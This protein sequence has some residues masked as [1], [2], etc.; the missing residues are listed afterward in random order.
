MLQRNSDASLLVC[1]LSPSNESHDW[2]SAASSNP[3]IFG[4]TS[5]LGRPRLKSEP[6]LL[7]FPIA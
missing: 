5:V 3:E 7:K 2:L 6:E 4:D 1:S